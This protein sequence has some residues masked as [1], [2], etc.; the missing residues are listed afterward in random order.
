MTISLLIDKRD[1]V[2]LVRDQI[3][4]IL[5]VETTSQQALALAA[6]PPKDPKFWQ[7]RVYTERSNPW[8]DFNQDETAQQ[9]PIVNIAI[10]NESFDKKS[11][12]VG[13]RQLANG[14]FNVD[15]YGHGI[16]ASTAS[17]HDSGDML[18]AFERD[19]AVRLVRNIL[20]ASVYTYLGLPRGKDQF[21]MGRWIQSIQYF[22]PQS[23]ERAIQNVQAA[24]IALQVDFNE[25]SPQ[26]EA[27]KIETITATIQRAPN[28]QVLLEAQYDF[29]P[30]T[31]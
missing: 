29:P 23:D 12:N 22:Q 20:M 10:D 8:D 15:V 19:R 28:G 26:Y 6:V 24:R 30:P 27:Q 17:G 21:V 25:L 31:P 13:S 16:S 2:E 4:T 11:G 7:L 18:A 9:L 1:A 14:T 3:A 5:L